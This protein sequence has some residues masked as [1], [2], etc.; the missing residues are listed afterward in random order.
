MGNFKVFINGVEDNLQHIIDGLFDLKDE[1]QIKEF[2][3]FIRE[4]RLNVDRN[5]LELVEIKGSD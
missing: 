3:K 1:K 4:G 2:I 5:I